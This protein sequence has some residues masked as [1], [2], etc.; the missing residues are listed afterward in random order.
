MLAA[1]L[2]SHPADTIGKTYRPT[3]LLHSLILSLYEE[4]IATEYWWCSLAHAP[5]NST[6]IEDLPRVHP[7]EIVASIPDR[8]PSPDDPNRP[9]ARMDEYDSDLTGYG[10]FDHYSVVRVAVS[11]EV[12]PLVKWVG[13]RTW[14]HTWRQRS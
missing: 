3:T 12:G 11:V 10:I 2:I 9:I 1:I 4:S 6:T 8:L 14:C 5:R 13:T 7:I